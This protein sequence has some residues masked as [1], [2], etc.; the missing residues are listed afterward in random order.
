MPQ[1][2]EQPLTGSRWRRSHFVACENPVVGE[3]A[4]TFHEQF[5]KQTSDGAVTFEEAGSLRKPFVDPTATFNLRSPVDDTL[6]LGA[7]GQPLTATYQDVYVILHSLYLA[8]ASAR[9]GV[10][11]P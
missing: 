11:L 8:L 3:K 7:N 10:T 2:Q 6:I 4:I 1:Y 5:V 9:D